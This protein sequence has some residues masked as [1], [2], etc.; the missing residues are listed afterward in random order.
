MQFCPWYPLVDAASHAPSSPGVWQVRLAKGLRDFPGGKSAMVQ[1][2]YADD[3]A[4]AVA[5][6]AAAY[7]AEAATWVCRHLIPVDDN[8]LPP[9]AELAAFCGKL[10]AQFTARFGAEPQP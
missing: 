9:N 5:T 7:P 10:R 1:Y 4:S 8:P 2:G 3:V 6:F